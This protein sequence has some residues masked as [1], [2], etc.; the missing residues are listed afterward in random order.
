MGALMIA[1]AAVLL[2]FLFVASF[3]SLVSTV[4]F[5]DFHPIKRWRKMHTP[6]CSE[7]LNGESEACHYYCYCHE[8][9]LAREKG[10]AE[11]R[12]RLPADMVRGTRYCHFTRGEME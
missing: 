6:P 8:A 7:C 5:N 12:E 1:A 9:L 4:Y 2:L 3:G 10:T 11:D